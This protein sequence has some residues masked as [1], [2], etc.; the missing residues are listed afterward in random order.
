VHEPNIPRS[1]DTPSP[2]AQ[3][4]CR[5]A[6]SVALIC[7]LVIGF[8][9]RANQLDYYS[10]ELDEFWNAELT[11]GWGTLHE[12]MPRN[13]IFVPPA[14]TKLQGAPG[15]WNILSH[16]TNLTHPPLFSILLR[17]WRDAFGDGDV[18]MRMFG[19]VLSTLTILPLYATVAMLAG[20]RAG[21]LTAAVFSLA[22]SSI[23]IAQQ[24]RP[25]NLVI[26]LQYTAVYLMV[27][28]SNRPIGWPAAI[29]LASVCLATVCTHYFSVVFLAA[30]AG[31]AGLRMDRTSRRRC[32]VAVAAAAMVFTLAWLPVMLQQRA[33]MTDAATSWMSDVDP[34][35]SLATLYRL[36]DVPFRLLAAPPASAKLVTQLSIV[37]ILIAIVAA[38]RR[39]ELR[40][41]L[42]LLASTVGFV[43]VLDLVQRTCL[44]GYLR[45]LTPAA[46]AMAA[47]AVLLVPTG[48]AGWK[49]WG[50][51][52]VPL[53]ILLA[54][55]TAL[56]DANKRTE[57]DFRPIAKFLDEQ[58]GPDDIVV[59]PVDPNW[60]W[61]A[62]F[63]YTTWS[64]YRGEPM[65]RCLFLEGT[66]D[67]Q[68][69]MQLANARRVWIVANWFD[70][71][72]PQHIPR[73][74]P[75]GGTSFP[76]VVTISEGRVAPRGPATATQQARDP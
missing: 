33:M 1:K 6:T 3:W 4:C 38:W 41:W 19:V 15:W 7:L 68:L 39:T 46:P 24:V 29:L 30:A 61:M 45:Y 21:L 16:Y 14:P 67:E 66:A 34:N 5:W 13:V 18:P 76:E 26:V 32:A 23:F 60:K 9:A 36:L 73:F 17:F 8:A 43:A 44:L 69:A 54:E 11:T 37:W 59:Y 56:P 55:V 2:A 12:T 63:L 49:R 42:Y 52:V 51:W 25:Y 50:A 75:L 71:D 10:L 31:F 40:L 53:A 64:H 65:V 47:L 22:S 27:R 48:A 72:A 35:P 58:V 57:P 28:A 70:A 20:R 74:Q 62:G